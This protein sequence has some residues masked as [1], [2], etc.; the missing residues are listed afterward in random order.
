MTLMSLVLPVAFTLLVWWFSTGLI[1]YLDGLPR[2]TYRHSLAGATALL[3]AALAGLAASSADT[4]ARGA[5]VAFTCAVAV[6]GWVEMTFLMGVLTGPRKAPC[7]PGCGDARRLV[8]AIQAILYHEFALLAAAAAIGGL[9]WAAPNRIG[10]GTFLVL[11]VMRT[12]AKL[13]MFFGVRNLYESFL[14]DHLSHMQTYFVRRPMNLLLPVV[15]AAGSLVATWMWVVATAEGADAFDA[16][17][18][19]LL[20]TMLTLAVIEHLF[21]VLPLPSERLWQW[22]M[23]SRSRKRTAFVPPAADLDRTMAAVRK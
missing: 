18:Y 3:I 19:S 23:R 14:P 10:M 6:W 11:W 17:G 8:Y 15:V 20:A 5:Y 1:L 4:S 9:T 12:S 7:P 21:L 16:T 22:A 13:N 2:R